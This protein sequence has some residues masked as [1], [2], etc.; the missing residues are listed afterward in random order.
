MKYV[1]RFQDQVSVVAEVYADVPREAQVY[2]I[3][4][5]ANAV[6]Q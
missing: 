6:I 4:P 2:D 1:F 3:S 5:R